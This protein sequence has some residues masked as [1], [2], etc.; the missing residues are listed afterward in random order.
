[1]NRR[2]FIAGGA[3]LGAAAVNAQTDTERERE[4]Q[5]KQLMAIQEEL[6]RAREEKERLFLGGSQP[7]FVLP[8]KPAEL[9]L[10]LQLWVIPVG[11]DYGAKLDWLEANGFSSVEIPSGD[12]LFKEADKFMAAMQGRKLKL[13]AACGPSDFSFAD[14][15]RRDKEV[16]RLMPMLDVLGKMGS[17][18]LIVCPARRRPELPF[19]ELRASFVE[20][21][22]RRLA[23]H[24]AECGTNIILEPLCR[25]ETP[26]LKLVADAASMAR[27]IGRGA[28][29]MG[30][31][32]HMSKEETSFC[33]AFLSAG[34]NLGHVHIA[35]LRSRK[36]PGYAGEADNYSDGFRGLKIIGYRGAISFECGYPTK[37]KD[38]NGKDI[39]LSEQEKV[40]LIIKARDLIREQWA[41]A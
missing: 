10:C 33:G 20:D 28:K 18:G 35:S 41:K 32:W 38:A 40:D 22:A 23:Q 24:A 26:F 19:E 13:S 29:P 37:G 21:T 11:G 8:A 9:N 39:H 34:E 1:M 3:A 6:R 27:D 25:G 2:E 36:I 30:D 12:W 31:F 15:A 4:E 16:D 5:R 17:T 7:H 14:K